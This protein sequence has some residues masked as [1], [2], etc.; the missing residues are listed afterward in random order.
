MIVADLINI[1]LKEKTYLKTFIPTKIIH[2]SDAKTLPFLFFIFSC[3]NNLF[4]K[5]RMEWPWGMFILVGTFLL[6]LFHAT[7]FAK[8]F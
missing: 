6:W 1:K 2:L 7:K 5:D 4:F 8:Y 3:V